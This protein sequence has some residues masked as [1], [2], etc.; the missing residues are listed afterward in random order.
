MRYFL[1]HPNGSETE[2]SDMI[3][4][5]HDSIVE[6]SFDLESVAIPSD[7]NMELSNVNGEFDHDAGI[8]AGVEITHFLVIVTAEERKNVLF[9]GVVADVK[10]TET[11]IVEIESHSVVASL[12]NCSFNMASVVG[13]GPVVE[14]APAK[15]VSDLLGPNGLRL[16]GVFLDSV[17]Y[18]Q[19]EAAEENVGLKMRLSIPAGESMT[20]SDFLQEI[21]RVTGAYV[22]S[23]N[24]LIRYARQGGFD[25]LGYDVTFSG[26]VI[27]GTVKNSRPVLWQKTKVSTVYWD[28]S[29]PQKI[30]K[31]MADFF[32]VEGESIMDEFREKEI[33]SD[34]LGDKLMHANLTSANAG[35]QEILGWR[36]RPRWQFE[37]EVDAI[38]QDIRGIAQSVPLL[39]RARLIWSGG[40]A[41]IVVVEKTTNDQKSIIKGLS[42][43]KPVFVHPA[44]R[45]LP[46]VTQ[47]VDEVTFNNNTPLN[48]V[49]YFKAEGAE[50]FSRHELPAGDTLVLGLE[51]FDPFIWK[52]SWGLPCGEIMSTEYEFEPEEIYM[53]SGMLDISDGAPYTITNGGPPLTPD[54]AAAT[55]RWTQIGRVVTAW[56]Y[57]EFNTGI[58]FNNF[59]LDLS[60]LAIPQPDPDIYA[61]ADVYIFQDTEYLQ[62]LW[63][64]DGFQIQPS[65]STVLAGGDV[66]RAQVTYRTA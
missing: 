7:F 19:A 3:L 6:M 36:G 45:L 5:A 59:V 24:G 8:F 32:D 4:R 46:V 42:L 16:P 9:I 25:R 26:E 58:T 60:A 37:F 50:A 33:E 54:F 49:V 52:V 14:A 41:Q 15:L 34:G 17:L 43:S 20:F 30:S 64:V 47:D 57:F 13:W 11:S 29:A 55:I 63:S 61:L 38:D 56:L 51:T 35:L 10:Y 53:A 22:Y 31:T 27:S 21:N 28:G 66:I 40:C 2:V 23:H 62:R 65:D 18:A 44:K 48:M 12:I 1:Q 39:S